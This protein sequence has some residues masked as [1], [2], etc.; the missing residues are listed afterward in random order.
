MARE[1]MDAKGKQKSSFNPGGD[2]AYERG[3]DARRKFWIKPLEENDLGLAQA[4][5]DPQKRPC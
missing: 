3:W 1:A 4:F 5:F 2:S